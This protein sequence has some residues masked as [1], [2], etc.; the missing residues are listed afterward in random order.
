MIYTRKNLR[1]MAQECDRHADELAD[2]GHADDAAAWRGYA[3]DWAILAHHI[4]RPVE[5]NPYND[6]WHLRVYKREDFV[7]HHK[8]AEHIREIVTSLE[9]G[10][11]EYTVH[12]PEPG[13]WEIRT[14]DHDQ[15]WRALDKH[16]DTESIYRRWLKAR[17]EC[18]LC[19]AG[20]CGGR[21]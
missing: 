8:W 5:R 11:V 21:K 7:D 9:K 1:L 16:F 10:G 3:D 12:M 20:S 17:E 14:P 18:P 13:T 2:F 15:Y 4:E 6:W 19:K